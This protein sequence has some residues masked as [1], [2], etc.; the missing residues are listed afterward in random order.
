MKDFGTGVVVMAFWSVFSVCWFVAF[1]SSGSTTAGWWLRLIFRRYPLIPHSTSRFKPSASH[2]SNIM[3]TQVN[4]AFQISIFSFS[5]CVSDHT[6]SC[7]AIHKIHSAK[8]CPG[9]EVN[10][11]RKHC[12]DKW[13]YPH[14]C[15]SHVKSLQ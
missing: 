5:R 4:L 1:Y 8:A 2:H 11:R 6:P 13:V 9:L 15:I 12:T 7:E 10:K 3:N 14:S